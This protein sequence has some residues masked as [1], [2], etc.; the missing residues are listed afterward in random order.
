[1]KLKA[2]A[3][4][5]YIGF[6]YFLSAH[7]PGFHPLFFPTLGAFAYL[8]ITRAA[9]LREM[10]LAACRAVVVSF[11]GSVL[12]QLH[13]STVFFVVNALF[14]FWLIH[15]RKWNMPPIMAVSFIPF[16]V[17]ASDLWR[18]PVFTAAAI[19]GLALTLALAAAVGRMRALQTLQ[20]ASGVHGT[21]AD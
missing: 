7:V 1:M 2:L 17:H 13:P 10:G 4:C 15:W 16:F 19:S 20:K 12:S 11:A 21:S 6:A 3:A 14:A 8:F 5:S 18:L 9:T